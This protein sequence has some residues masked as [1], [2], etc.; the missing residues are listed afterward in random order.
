M[1]YNII[2]WLGTRDID[3]LDT[4]ETLRSYKVVL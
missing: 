1:R 2:Q 4:K 3:G